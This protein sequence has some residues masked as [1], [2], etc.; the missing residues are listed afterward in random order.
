MS[1]DTQ[2]DYYAL[3]I[4]AS[5]PEYKTK[6]NLTQDELDFIDLVLELRGKKG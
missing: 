1:E 5:D 2:T 6:W 4:I 3:F